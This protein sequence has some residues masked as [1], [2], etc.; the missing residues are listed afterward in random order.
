[1]EKIR[2]RLEQEVLYWKKAVVIAIHVF[3]RTKRYLHGEVLTRPQFPF[4]IDVTNLTLRFN[5][6]PVFQGFDGNRLIQSLTSISGKKRYSF[7]Q[8]K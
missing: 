8:F 4:V 5:F 6:S 3:Y 1:M 7:N 2:D